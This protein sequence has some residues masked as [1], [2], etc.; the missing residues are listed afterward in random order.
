MMDKCGLKSPAERLAWI[1]THPRAP[2]GMFPIAWAVTDPNVIAPLDSPLRVALNA[3]LLDRR[4]GPWKE[5]YDAV[6]ALESDTT[7]PE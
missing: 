6:V 7:D 5:M 1:A 3:R 4:K 2:M